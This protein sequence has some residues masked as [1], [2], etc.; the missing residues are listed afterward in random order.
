[1]RAKWIWW[2][3][4]LLLVVALGGLVIYRIQGQPI[5]DTVNAGAQTV[6]TAVVEK[7]PQQNIMQ[8]TGTVDA[9]E[10]DLISARVAGIVESLQADNGELIE[11]G[12]TLVQI[13]GQAYQRLVTINT[14]TLTQA[15][16]KLNSTR[17][18]FKR[19]QQLHE[20]GAVSDQDYENM[21]AALTAAEADV[22]SAQAALDNAQKDLSYTRVASPRSG[23][24][25]NR[26]VLRGQMVAQGTPLMEVHNLTE[27]KV[28]V[29]IS[30]SELGNIKLGQSAEIT[31]DAF[32]NQIFN[33]TLTSINQAVSPQARAFMVEIKTA[34][35]DHLLRAGMFANV[36]IYTGEE[37]TI[38]SI[39]ESALTSKQEQ[40]YVFIPEGNVV[41]MVAVEIGQ[42]Y[43]GRV[44]IKQGLIEGQTV[45]N[46]NVNKL[47]TGD[48]IQI[49]TEQ[50]V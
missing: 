2:G 29:S 4:V 6:K 13:D 20:A 24:V 19:T 25:V 33:G 28:I 5:S 35:P 43:D 18:T 44:E 1:M 9:V 38:L 12:Q 15:Q 49:A 26:N 46:S 45:I 36:K 37:T 17:S 7:S 21:Q 32:G 23:L 42:I 39:P 27:V 10:K 41:K 11:A 48:R 3:I 47:K 50:G 22:T 14:A 34:N 8:I 30:Q 16:A 40:F 31:V